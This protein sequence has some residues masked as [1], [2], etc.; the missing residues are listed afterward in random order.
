MDLWGVHWWWGRDEMQTSAPG[1]LPEG[2]E[3]SS[4]C[5]CFYVDQTSFQGKMRAVSIKAQEHALAMM[6]AGGTQLP[7]PCYVT[8]TH[9]FSSNIN[10]LRLA[11]LIPHCTDK[12]TGADGSRTCP[13]SSSKWA[14]DLKLQSKPS[15]PAWAWKLERNRGG[16]DCHMIPPCLHP[17]NRYRIRCSG[18]ISWLALWS[19]VWSQ[20]LG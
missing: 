7:F 1:D 9:I 4:L 8:S 15:V 18:S 13:R 19:A 2:T 16:F 14:Q 20:V 17:M 12:E 3:P 10:S 5:L 11:L 6:P